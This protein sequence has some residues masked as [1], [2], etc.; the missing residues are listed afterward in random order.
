MKYI[1]G[2]KLLFRVA[3]IGSGI[4][5]AVCVLKGFRAMSTSIGGHGDEAVIAS[6]Q[7]GNEAER[8]FFLSMALLVVAVVLL[9]VIKK[10]QT[11]SS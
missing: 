3:I 11:K 7:Y 9:F 10:A 2:Y 6:K 8:F 4:S 5:F 1:W